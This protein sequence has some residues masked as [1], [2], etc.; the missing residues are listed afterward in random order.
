MKKEFVIILCIII[1]LI[2]S[3]N[4]FKKKHD[5][6]SLFE[7]KKVENTIGNISFVDEFIRL[8][9]SVSIFT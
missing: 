2:L 9:S 8:I 3:N 4:K 6:K 1:I 5:G 7:E